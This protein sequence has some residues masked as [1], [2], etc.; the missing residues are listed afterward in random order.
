MATYRR[1][2]QLNPEC[3]LELESLSKQIII[4][5]IACPIFDR[6]VFENLAIMY[7][8]F[9][10]ID[11]PDIDYIMRIFERIH[12]I[13]LIKKSLMASNGKIQSMEEWSLGK[14]LESTTHEN[15]HTMYVSCRCCG[16]NKKCSMDNPLDQYG[17]HEYSSPYHKYDSLSTHSMKAAFHTCVFA[18]DNNYDLNI[19]FNATLLALFHDVGKMQTVNTSDYKSK[20][21]I[22]FTAHGEAG[23]IMWNMLWTD[24]MNE[25]IT[26]REYMDIGIAIGRHMCG[27]HKPTGPGSDYKL[28]TLC[29][30]N[31]RNVNDLLSLLMIGDHEGKI[32]ETYVEFNPIDREIFV[33]R[34]TTNITIREY[35]LKYNL[36]PTIIISLVG[37]SGVGKSFLASIIQSMFNVS[38]CSRDKIIASVCVGINERLIGIEY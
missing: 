23:N 24:E 19:V 28:D 25:Y 10:Y 3:V 18:I 27:Y 30:F 13:C 16:K 35:L 37:R 26:D 29:V 32:P 5:C 36:P 8:N 7:C 31:D 20:L 34:T 1:L 9:I 22:S 33:K 14:L 4:S 15:Y 6:S 17:N 38:I 11:C 21:I 12:A 2:K